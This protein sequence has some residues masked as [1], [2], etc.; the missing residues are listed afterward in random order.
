MNEPVHARPKVHESPE[1]HEADDLAGMI[2]ARGI[3]PGHVFPGVGEGVLEAEGEPA[4]LPVDPL[5]DDLHL[6]PFRENVAHLFGPAPGDLG[7]REQA[8]QT[9]DVHEGAELLERGHGPLDLHSLRERFFQAVPLFL[10]LRLHDGPAGE[11]D[12]PAALAVFYDLEGQGPAHGVG[13]IFLAPHSGLGEGAEG[14]H[15]AADPYLEA[16]LHFLRNRAFHGDAASPGVFELAMARGAG[17]YLRCEVQLV[18]PG[19][20]EVG[21][22]TVAFFD[23]EGPRCV[24]QLLPVEIPLAF[25][26]QVEEDPFR[27]DLDD[28]RLHHLSGIKAALLFEALFEQRLEALFTLPVVR[29]LIVVLHI[30]PFRNH[31][32][33]VN[34]IVR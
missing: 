14:P 5:D 8:F 13:W 30:I 28:H 23:R 33:S 29:R 16:A 34:S 12:V 20:E 17:A 27:R 3:V 19:G 18:V 32:H 10:L 1:G 11:H 25:S 21:A 9:A 2:R 6:L 24:E 7:N 15:I 26:P 22:D 31:V 4:L